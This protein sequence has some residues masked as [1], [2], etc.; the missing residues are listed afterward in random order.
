MQIKPITPTKMAIIK[1]FFNLKISSVIKDMEKWE[2]AYHA[3]RNVKCW[4]HFENSL[5]LPQNVKYNITL[6]PRNSTPSETPRD[7]K[8]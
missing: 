3:G 4:S 8:T 2:P 6:W 5:A 1:K 7:L